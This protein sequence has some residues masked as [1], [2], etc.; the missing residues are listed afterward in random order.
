VRKFDEGYYPWAR[1]FN[2]I[3]FD[4]AE[5]NPEEDLYDPPKQQVNRLWVNGPNRQFEKGLRTAQFPDGGELGYQL[6]YLMEPDS[7]P[8]QRFWLDRL[9][10]EIRER[11]PFAVLGRYVKNTPL[12]SHTP[13]RNSFSLSPIRSQIFIHLYI[14]IHTHTHSKYRGDNWYDFY[15]D[16]SIPLIN[17]INGNAVYNISSILMNL[18][19]SQLEM[20]A[21]QIYNFIP[22][23]LRMAQVRI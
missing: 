23:D 9:R 8:L 3:Y 15:R 19:L 18:M 6:A 5:M 20:E 16:L 1:C 17:H 11:Q 12:L 14:P 7:V 13:T 22:F 21:D 10:R 4:T 2:K